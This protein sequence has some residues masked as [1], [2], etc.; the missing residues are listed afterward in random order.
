MAEQDVVRVVEAPRLYEVTSRLDHRRAHQPQLADEHQLRGLAGAEVAADH[1]DQRRG[2]PGLYVPAQPT[3]P[4]VGE[5]PVPRRGGQVLA[6]LELDGGSVGVLGQPHVRLQRHDR[7]RRVVG[8]ARVAHVDLAHATHPVR[9]EELA[10]RPLR[11]DRQTTHEVRG[12][13]LLRGLAQDGLARRLVGADRDRGVPEHQ[14]HGR[15]DVAV[16]RPQRLQRLGA[17]ELL[18][19][20]HAADTDGHDRA[21]PG[22]E[23]RERLFEGRVRGG[24]ARVQPCLRAHDRGRVPQPVRRADDEPVAVGLEPLPYRLR[25]P[26]RREQ[27]RKDAQRQAPQVAGTGHGPRP[28]GPAGFVQRREQRARGWI[29]HEE[30]AGHDGPTDAGAVRAVQPDPQSVAGHAHVRR[31]VDAG[32]IPQGRAEQAVDPA[33]EQEQGVLAQR[34]DRLEHPLERAERGPHAELVG[35]VDVLGQLVQRGDRPCLQQPQGAVGDG[36]L[37][38]LA[39]P[40][41]LLHGHREPCDA[42]RLLVVERPLLAG[43]FAGHRAAAR[44][45]DDDDALVALGLLE[46]DAA[47][48]ADVVVRDD[49][50]RDQRLAQPQRGVD[51]H[52]VATPGERVGGERD[53]R[54]VGG[55]LLLHDDRQRDV[56]VADP[57]PRPVADRARCPQRAPAP[58]DRVEHR[59]RSDDV[60]V[61]VLLAR[62]R[63]F[64]EVLRGGRGPYGDGVLADRGEGCTDG[65]GDLVGHDGRLERGPDQGGCALEFVGVGATKRTE[66]GVDHVRQP[67]RLDD[68]LVRRRGHDEAGR[69]GEAATRQP[70]E[71]DGL[72]AATGERERGGAAMAEDDDVSEHCHIIHPGARASPTDPPRAWS[73]GVGRARHNG[74]H[75]EEIDT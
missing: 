42:A 37:D 29:G 11:D 67:V 58:D 38:V 71:V 34:R 17:A 63:G 30:H 52:S 36:P 75:N 20:P 45:A 21:E 61:R 50:T 72:A 10:Q 56:V 68:R 23:G 4:Q 49:L 64:R 40:V 62:E 41:L 32:V 46:H 65:G 22:E 51:D 55:D 6:A 18:Q 13:D 59:V 48:R 16:E 2:H 53:A 44:D 7:A 3:G 70:Y 54:C 27:T 35:G 28:L 1:A 33:Y 74:V 8:P 43:A 14:V 57:G 24:D 47:V 69:H 31:E 66:L 73:S 60:E 15:G 25:I 19:D 26:E 9:V 39:E 12:G 5:Q